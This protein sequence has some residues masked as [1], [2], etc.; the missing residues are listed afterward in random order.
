MGVGVGGWGAGQVVIKMSMVGNA[1]AAHAPAPLKSWVTTKSPKSRSCV[2]VLGGGAAEKVRGTMPTPS[3]SFLVTDH[4]Q[5]L[6]KLCCEALLLYP[7]SALT[8]FHNR[9]HLKALWE[10]GCESLLVFVQIA[11]KMVIKTK[12]HHYRLGLW[13]SQ[14]SYNDRVTAPHHQHHAGFGV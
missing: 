2:C 10:F 5:T 3:F 12:V 7:G 14:S 1:S 6:Q 11:V 4:R 9:T 13:L 8:S